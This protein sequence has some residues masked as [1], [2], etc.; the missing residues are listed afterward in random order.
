M[1]PPSA[2]PAKVATR[3]GS[4]GKAS[5]VKRP[6]AIFISESVDIEVTR[7]LVDHHH[8]V[9]A[10]FARLHTAVEDGTVEARGNGRK[11]M[12]RFILAR[13]FEPQVVAAP[14]H[15]AAGAHARQP[16][17]E[18]PIHQRSKHEVHAGQPRT[19]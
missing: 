10:R 14:E 1:T 9:G 4:C 13:L 2:T 17:L 15:A 3:I 12:P 8:I 16:L 11:A 19:A 5:S 6:K 18:V 7:L